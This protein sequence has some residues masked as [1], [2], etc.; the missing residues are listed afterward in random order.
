M[1]ARVHLPRE[2]QERIRRHLERERYVS[3]RELA[4]REDVSDMTIRRDLEALAERGQVR[5]VFGGAHVAETAV[6]QVYVERMAQHRAAKER[7][8][9]HALRLVA[10]GETVALDGSTTSV[11]L[12]RRLKGRDVTVVTTSLLVAQELADANVEVVLPGGVLRSRTLCLV[13]PLAERSLE[14]FHVDTVFFSGGGVHATHGM[15][16]THDLEAALKRAL[17]GIGSRLAALIDSSKFDRKALHPL[18]RLSE[19]DALVS[20]AQ[21]PP[22]IAEALCCAGVQVEVADG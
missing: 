10:D 14:R 9:E 19:V 15:T 18:A 3:V 11:Y 12:A 21:P 5:R 22:E 7:I 4:A 16:D 13:G 20:E 8:A 1:R 6:E 2:R 17:F